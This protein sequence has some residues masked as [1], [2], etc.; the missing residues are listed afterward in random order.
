VLVRW[1]GRGKRSG[2]ELREMGAKGAHVFHIHGG[3][4]T[5]FVLY[6]DRQRAF[7]DLGIAA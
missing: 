1:S 5:K 7:A 6:M 4:V 2:L 3:K